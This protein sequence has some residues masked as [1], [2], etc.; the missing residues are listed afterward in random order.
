M[1]SLY[2]TAVW[3]YNTTSEIHA[4]PAPLLLHLAAYHTRTH[5]TTQPT[6]SPMPPRNCNRRSASAAMHIRDG[7]ERVRARLQAPGDPDGEY[8]HEGGGREGPRHK[9]GHLLRLHHAQGHGVSR[10][11][12]GG[13]EPVLRQQ[14]EDCGE[15]LVPFDD[16]SN[17]EE[18]PK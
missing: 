3:V 15:C 6:C 12:I 8:G 16:S 2:Q 1:L 17:T 11:G 13:V 10:C 18:V 14:G 9:H 5:N 7:G 4:S